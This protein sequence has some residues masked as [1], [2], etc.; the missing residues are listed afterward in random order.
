MKNRKGVSEMCCRSLEGEV[1]APL[2]LQ[3]VEQ[4]NVLR[5]W[6][7]QTSV[8]FNSLGL[9]LW[10]WSLGAAGTQGPAL[11]LAMPLLNG[12]SPRTSVVYPNF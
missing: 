11:S 2:S 10:L 1:P 3:V 6:H 9:C 5:W 7:L 4:H 12:C 8:P